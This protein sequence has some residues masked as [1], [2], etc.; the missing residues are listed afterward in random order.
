MPEMWGKNVY[1]NL[2]RGMKKY[3][4]GDIITWV[5]AVITER[6][7]G[8]D[9]AMPNKQKWGL[10]G[11][12][13][14]VDAENVLVRFRYIVTARGNKLA[15]PGEHGRLA[16]FGTTH[17]NRVYPSV[18]ERLDDSASVKLML[19]WLIYDAITRKEKVTI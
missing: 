2:E 16:S 19:D 12:V 11:I 17:P 3:K 5:P 6:Y 4:I 13:T 15:V 10:R 1:F 9:S 14:A 18:Y 8:M 7:T